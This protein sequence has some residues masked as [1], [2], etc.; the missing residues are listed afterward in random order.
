MTWQAISF[1]SLSTLLYSIDA[2]DNVDDETV[3]GGVATPFMRSAF[4]GLPFL[5]DIAH[6]ARHQFSV[7]VDP[8][9]LNRRI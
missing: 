2:S 1:Q 8:T 5:V 7:S 4:Q 6:L 9:L 3:T